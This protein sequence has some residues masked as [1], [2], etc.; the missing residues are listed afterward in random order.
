MEH[1]PTPK[2]IIIGIMLSWT[3]Y[4]L[5]PTWQFQN[6]SEEKKEALRSS[7]DLEQ[8]E[9]KIIRQ[10]LD[11]RGGMYIV[12]E[13]DIPTLVGNLA[14]LKDERLASVIKKA[15]EAAIES[16]TDFLTQFRQ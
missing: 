7:G 6:M 14:D 4:A 13:A 16:N 3:V 2:Y 10:G 15:N 12:L 9:S 8:I 1:N 11:L 5:Y